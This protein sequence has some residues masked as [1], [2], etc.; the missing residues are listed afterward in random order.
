MSQQSYCGHTHQRN[1]NWKR[2]MYFG[3]NFSTVYNSQHKEAT[4]KSI[5][6]NKTAVVHIHNVILL[7][8]WKECIW[9][10]SNEVDETGACYTEWSKSER[11]PPIQYSSVQLLSWVRLFATSWTAALQASL[12]ITNSRGPPKPVSIDAISDAIQPSHPL[13]SPSPPAPNPSQHQG[14]FKWVSSLH[15]VA[16]VLEFQLQHQSFQWTP[17][18]DL[19]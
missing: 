14:L 18:T 11:K 15:Q 5:G 3:I 7:S 1:Q 19:L 13:S 16:K 2:H 4:W 10:S 6:R 9:I 8:H 17:R 12:P